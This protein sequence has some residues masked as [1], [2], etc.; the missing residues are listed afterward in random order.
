MTVNYVPGG[1]DALVKAE[2]QAQEGAKT[3]IVCYFNPKEITVDKPVPWQK[4]KNVEGNEPT[5]EFTAA[6]P[7]LL[8]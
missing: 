3:K 7:I 8:A 2:I 1:S 4:H 5:L 6:E